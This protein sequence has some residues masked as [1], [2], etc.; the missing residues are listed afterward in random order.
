MLLLVLLLQIVV[1]TMIISVLMKMRD[2]VGGESEVAPGQEA[3]LIP[4]LGDVVRPVGS[5]VLL[6]DAAFLVGFLAKMARARPLA[7]PEPLL[8]ERV[9]KAV[10]EQD[11]L[12]DAPPYCLSALTEQQK[13]ELKTALQRVRRERKAR[14]Q[15][16]YQGFMFDLARYDLP[17]IQL[18]MAEFAVQPC[19]TIDVTHRDLSIYVIEI[20]QWSVK[21]F[22]DS[23]SIFRKCIFCF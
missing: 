9:F 21:N 3:M 4:G 7:T 17:L 11:P 10:V 6:G 13:R 22:F 2:R 8:R 23:V 16:D 15:L 18:L 14:L 1:V 12:R 5:V 19:N 20:S